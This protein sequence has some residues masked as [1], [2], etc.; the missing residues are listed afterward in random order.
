MELGPS[1]PGH[2]PRGVE[3]ALKGL[4]LQGQAAELGQ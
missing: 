3:T 1:T 2:V 4:W